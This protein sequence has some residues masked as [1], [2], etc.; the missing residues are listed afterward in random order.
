ML[1]TNHPPVF[2]PVDLSMDR[3]TLFQLTVEYMAWVN[4]GIEV[5]LQAT[6]APQVGSVQEYVA[7]TLDAICGKLP[8]EGAFYLVEQGGA[9]AG[10]CGLRRI[11]E[12]MAE[13]KRIYVRPS[14]RGLGLG[15]AM[16]QRLIEDAKAFG[17]EKAV[18]DSAPFMH[19]AQRLY[20]AAGFTDRPPYPG[21]EAPPQLLG[22][23]RFMERPL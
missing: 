1:Q 19:A 3:E 17:C 15:E 9:V 20:A 23:W 22:V 4:R 2:R 6:E 8:P 13:F 12:R 21:S 5:E 11:A 16:L 10:M 7:R 18:L 14:H